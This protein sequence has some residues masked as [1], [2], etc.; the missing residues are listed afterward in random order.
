MTDKEKA[1][2]IDFH[3]CFGTEA[4]KRVW[5]HLRKKFMLDVGYV[6]TMNARSEQV[7]QLSGS[8]NVIIY[9]MDMLDK[10]IPA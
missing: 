6:A 4:G 7:I 3:E 8:R 5:R 2:I 1:L 9:I 10:E